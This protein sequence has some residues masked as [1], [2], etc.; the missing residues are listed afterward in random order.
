M[1]LLR[2]SEVASELRVTS[3]AVYQWIRKG[4][5]TSIRIGTKTVRVSREELRNF[6]HRE[7]RGNPD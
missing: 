7:G 4:R 2:V 3:A 1:D 5:L 6:L